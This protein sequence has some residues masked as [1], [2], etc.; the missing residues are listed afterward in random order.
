MCM[1]GRIYTRIRIY[2]SYPRWREMSLVIGVDLD[3][4]KTFIDVVFGLP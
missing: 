3:I 4:L 2:I 1:P